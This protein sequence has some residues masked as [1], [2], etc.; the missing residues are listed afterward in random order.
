MVRQ[1]KILAKVRRG[2]VALSTCLH[3]TDPS[4]YELT[5]LLG[6]D[7]IWMDMEHHGY[8][9]E[10]AGHLM[11]AARVGGTDIVA[12]PGKGEFMRMARML[13][14]GA[15]GIMYP[16]CDGPEE[17]REVVRW[18]KFAPLGQRGFDGSGA[19]V[20][21]VLTPMKDYVRL[22]NEQTFVL[23]QMEEPSAIERADE[24]AAVPGVDM[25][26]LGP[27]DFSVLTGIPGQFDHPSVAGAIEK[28]ARAAKKHG[29]HWAATCGTPEQA[30]R[31]VDMGCRLLFHGADI[32]WVKNGLEQIKRSFGEQLGVTF[33]TGANGLGGGAQHYSEAK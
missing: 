3:L 9:L 24:I 2:Q 30:K 29:K 23:I 31:M 8:S 20:P 5:S 19:D 15:T 18:A 21:Y 7:G 22:A 32:V 33:G 25:L 27:A 1:S 17:A 6:F 4:V 14:M 16:R 28:I 26:M 11:R 13:E 10:T 12:R